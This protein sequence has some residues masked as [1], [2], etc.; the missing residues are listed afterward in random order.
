MDSCVRRVVGCAFA[1]VRDHLRPAYDGAVEW[2]FMRTIKSIA[3]LTLSIV[4]AWPCFG[5]GPEGH[6]IIGDIATRYLSAKSKAA[7]KELLGD[8]SLADVSNW[9]DE[10][11]KDSAYDYLKPLH[12]INVPRSAAKIDLSRDCKNEQ[13]VIGAIN[14]YTEVLKN[15]NST[16]E[17]K[18][19]ALKL[20]VHFVG[21]VHQPLHVSYAEDLGG[22]KVKVNFL[23]DSQRNLHAVWD[24]SLIEHQM[25]GDR[26]AM[27]KDLFR[28]L[29]DKKLKQYRAAANPVDWGNESLTITRTL[30]KDVP[31]QGQIM[32][33]DEAY[34]QRQAATINDRLS[35]AG[36]RLAALLNSIFG[37]DKPASHP[38][39]R[40]ATQPATA[41]ATTTADSPASQP[42]EQ[43]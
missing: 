11:R 28:K 27:E 18:I 5:W 22:N 17:E 8:Q 10:V 42:A 9:A 41:P 15:K 29:T 33:I 14:H 20:I 39:T 35:A 25:K 38:T 12:Y 21:D 19:T 43:Q 1:V 34:C 32:V 37:E 13:C 2:L 23:G 36:V 30:Y 26:E 16:R 6:R 40:P 3:F 7:I 24:S 4:L 31:R